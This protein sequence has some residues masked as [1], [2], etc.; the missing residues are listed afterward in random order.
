MK[1]MI[2][3]EFSSPRETVNFIMRG[4]DINVV[5]ALGN[6]QAIL[7]LLR[8][9]Q[10]K[11]LNPKPYAFPTIKI[12]RNLSVTHTGRD[13]YRYGVDNYGN[14]EANDNFLIFYSDEMM[15][16]LNEDGSIWSVD[17]TFSVVPEP[18]KQLFTISFIK[19]NHVFPA[20]YVL[21]KNKNQ[22]TYIE[23][24]NVLNEKFPL[25]HPRIIKTDFEMASINALRSSFPSSHISGCLFHLNQSLVENYKI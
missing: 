24:F 3:N 1:E 20:C 19:N 18:Y 2:R 10:E 8:R 16:Y 25:T 5:R 6:F 17:G 22:N 14:L 9:E 23:M 15:Q 11:S 4:V 12:S 7:R 13:F 21:M